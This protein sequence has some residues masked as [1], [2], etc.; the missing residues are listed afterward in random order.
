MPLLG[1]LLSNASARALN[2]RL[3]VLG[4]GCQLSPGLPAVTRTFG[5]GQAVLAVQVVCARAALGAVVALAVGLAAQRAGR[6]QRSHVEGRRR[7]DGRQQSGGRAGGP[8]VGDL[9]G[10]HEGA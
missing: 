2:E 4:T 7:G 6:D 5:A 8:L 9:Q 10:V 3:A 1:C